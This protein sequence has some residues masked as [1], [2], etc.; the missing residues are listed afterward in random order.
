LL[1]FSIALLTLKHYQELIREVQKSLKVKAAVES[2]IEMGEVVST[3][4]D[5]GR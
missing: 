1:A 5:T 3:D 2:D 4:R